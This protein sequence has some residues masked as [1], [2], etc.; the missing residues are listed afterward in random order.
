MVKWLKKGKWVGIVAMVVLCIAFILAGVAAYGKYQMSKIPSLTFDEALKYTTK[1]NASAVITVGVIDNGYASYKVYGENGIELPP[2]LH[3]YEIGSLTKTFTAALVNKAVTEGKIHMDSPIDAYLPLPAGN[4]YPTVKNLLTH[5]SGYKVFYFEGPMIANFFAGRNDFYGVTREMVLAKVGSLG[6]DQKS[7]DFVYSN[8]GYAV[9]GLVLEAAYGMDYTTLA[10]DF[11]QNELGLAHTKISDGSGDLANYW[12][13]KD[14]DAYLPAGAF[15][16]NISDMLSYAQL[17]LGGSPLF[18][19]CHTAL[20]E[21]HAST[22]EYEM[23]GIRMDEIGMAWILDS[24]NDILW[25]NG[26]TGDY[27]TPAQKAR[28]KRG[29]VI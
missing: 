26:G 23:M 3:T 10:N 11:A 20:E 5:T 1:D 6:T 21:I 9:L 8:Y 19:G 15:T 14:R 29:R 2:Q 4:E 25:H 18:A 24:E 12:D 22:K 27:I 7:H 13:W 16:S 28:K 17:Q